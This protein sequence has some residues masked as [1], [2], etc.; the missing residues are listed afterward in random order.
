MKYINTITGAI[1][2]SPCLISGENWE[3]VTENKSKNQKGKVEERRRGRRNR[4]GRIAWKV[5]R[6]LKI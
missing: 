6:L 5:L 4:R 1:I 3:L 2:D